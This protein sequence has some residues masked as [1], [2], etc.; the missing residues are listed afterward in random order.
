MI[1][2]FA[3]EDLPAVTALWN[4]R[5][6]RDGFVEHTTESFSALFL[7]NKYFSVQHTF[8]LEEAGALGFVCG[9]SGDDLPAGGERG[10]FTCLVLDEPVDTLEHTR[11]LLLHLENS[12]LKIGKTVSDVL[13]FNPIHLPWYIP[14]T[15]KHQHNNAP[16][17]AVDTLLYQRLLA[18]GYL[19]RGR[20]CAMYLDLS[21]FSMPEGIQEKAK[22]LLEK[23]Y[24]VDLYDQKRCHGLSEMLHGLN[25]PIWIKEIEES[26]L[27][28]IPFLVAESDGLVVGFAGPIYPEKSGRGY[29]TGI[30]VLPE[31]EGK[32]FGKQLFYHLCEQEK[33]RGAQYMSLFTG[34]NN[35]ARRIY[36][37]AGFVAVKSFAILRKELKGMNNDE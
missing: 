35:P 37:G 30:G 22:A 14:N 36:E 12:F 20:E 23:G 27:K 32:G 3:T 18:C 19:E 31:W 15:N 6:V 25:N 21:R 10:Y 29:F 11:L 26:A 4:R 16:G 13:F 17:V 1:R 9:C 7:Q 34:E 28:G 24:R 2:H 5:A 33:N 8:I